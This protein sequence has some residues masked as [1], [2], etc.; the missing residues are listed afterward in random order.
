MNEPHFQQTVADPG[1]PLQKGTLVNNTA[2]LPESPRPPSPFPEIP[3]FTIVKKLGAGGMGVVYLA[4][5]EGMSRRVAIEMIR[6]DGFSDQERQRF[7]IE[8]RLIANIEH[9]NVVRIYHISERGGR[10]FFVMEYCAGGCL[11]DWLKRQPQAPKLAAELTLKIA[12]GVAAAHRANIIHRDLKPANILVGNAESGLRNLDSK[13]SNLDSSPQPE[14]SLSGTALLKI[15]DF[16][17]AKDLDSSM[18]VTAKSEAMMGTPSYMSPEQATGKAKEATKATDVWSLGVILYEMLTGSLPFVGSTVPEVVSKVANA[19]PIVPSD[20]VNVPRDL[21]TICLKCLRKDPADRYSSAVE[22]ADDLRRFLIGESISARP[23]SQ[24]EKSV[25]WVKKNRTIAG[26]MAAVTV[27]LMLGAAVSIFYAMLSNR[28]LAS[29]NQHAEDAERQSK[30]AK[31]SADDLSMEL[32]TSR[33][34]L[35]LGRLRT[36][37]AD[38]GNNAVQVALDT[39]EE[40]APENRCLGWHY[41][42]RQIEGRQ[43]ATYLHADAVRSV[44]L[45]PDG[46]RFATGSKDHTAHLW[47]VRT[48]ACLQEFKGHT[49]TVNSVALRVDGSRLASGSDDATARLWDV[50][51]VPKRGEFD[52][53]ERLMRMRRIRPDPDWHVE[54]QMKFE[55]EKN[56]YAAALQRSFEQHDRGLMAFENNQFDKAY[57]HFLAAALMKPPVPKAVEIES[58]K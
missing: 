33:R 51:T 49:G 17:L 20:R 45:N 46:S 39:L 35:D 48:G 3:G 18:G 58:K 34:L 8:A 15:T 31:E 26:L 9:P 5:Q 44:S 56:P 50:R 57:A 54:Q 47:D 41:L 2:W 1:A 23:M 14:S 55:T 13:T 21:E 25:R 12:E 24:M 36:A 37:Q 42:R 6:D 30:L 38:F 22:L 11:S 28:N 40:I 4:E 27:S 32:K 10:P 29:A 16:G 19:D 7:Q 53:E 52:E 43:I